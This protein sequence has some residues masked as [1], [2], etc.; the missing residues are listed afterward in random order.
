MVLCASDECT[1]FHAIK[2][3]RDTAYTTIGHDTFRFLKDI[4]HHHPK[5]YIFPHPQDYYNPKQKYGNTLT[6]WAHAIGEALQEALDSGVIYEGSFVHPGMEDN[7]SLFMNPLNPGMISLAPWVCGIDR[8]PDAITYNPS[9]QRL[10]H[11]S[12]PFEPATISLFSPTP[13]LH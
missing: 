12:K 13:F 1:F 9:P 7:L 4:L 11:S 8:L 3:S 5:F 2:C 10:S 6:E